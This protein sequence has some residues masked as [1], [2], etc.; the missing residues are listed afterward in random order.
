MY[1]K[2]PDIIRL[3]EDPRVTPDELLPEAARMYLQ[4]YLD[5]ITYRTR[6]ACRMPNPGDIWSN[7]TTELIKKIIFNILHDYGL[8]ASKLRLKFEFYVCGSIAKKQATPYSD[9]DGFIIWE[10]PKGNPE[11]ERDLMNLGL[12]LKGMYFLLHRIFANTSQLSPDQ[13]GITP[14]NY[15]GTVDQLFIKLAQDE[16]AD[17]IPFLGAIATAKPLM[18]EGLFLEQLQCK[19]NERWRVKN[20]YSSTR[21]YRNLVNVFAGPSSKQKIHLK[22]D[23]FRPLDLFIMALCNDFNVNYPDR[24]HLATPIAVRELVEQGKMAHEFADF[25]LSIFND[26]IKIRCKAHAEAKKEQDIIIFA[27]CDPSMQTILHQL[28]DKI[29]VVRGI[30]AARLERLDQGHAPDL[31]KLELTS[32]H[33]APYQSATFTRAE[34]VLDLTPYVYSDPARLYFESERLKIRQNLARAKEAKEIIEQM[35]LGIKSLPVHLH[36]LAESLTFC[37]EGSVQND[38]GSIEASSEL[39]VGRFDAWCQTFMQNVVSDLFNI[40]GE[41]HPWMKKF[42]TDA[43]P[44]ELSLEGKHQCAEETKKALL[45]AYFSNLVDD[46]IKLNPVAAQITADNSLKESFLAAVAGSKQR[47]VELTLSHSIEKIIAEKQRPFQDALRQFKTTINDS[48]NLLQGIRARSVDNDL[49]RKIDY[50]IDR[51]RKLSA[52]INNVLG[53]KC[54]QINS[55]ASFFHKSYTYFRN[56]FLEFT[57]EIRGHKSNLWTWFK[58]KIRAIKNTIIRKDLFLPN[59]AELV[60]AVT[61]EINEVTRRHN[62]AAVQAALT[63]SYSP[64]VGA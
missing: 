53:A 22:N 54:K 61:S 49:K 63:Q 1:A 39:N 7:Y 5:E 17:V 41:F 30:A 27:D 59:K 15:Q 3:Y 57:N 46:A 45:Q 9:F 23:I 34:Q 14:F 2:N 28:V 26:A 20:G 64:R 37:F 55:H 19:I 4:G 40:E 47:C 18:C 10:D 62:D 21:L 33:A 6:E 25:L 58:E 51:Y 60:S 52:D 8:E 32:I 13:L 31:A 48:I 50:R 16:V 38:D 56:D 35:F 11:K 24:G 36:Y 29:A 42:L 12:A 44:Y 43:R